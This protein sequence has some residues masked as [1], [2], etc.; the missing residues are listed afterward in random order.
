[1]I[2]SNRTMSHF[3]FIRVKSA[4]SLSV[5]HN[6]AFHYVDTEELRVDWPIIIYIEYRT[7]DRSYTL[8]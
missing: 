3:F 1:M 4:D 6:Y 2:H 7:I 5:K 8:F